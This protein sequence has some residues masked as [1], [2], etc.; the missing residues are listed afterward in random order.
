MSYASYIVPISILFLL[1]QFN[2]VQKKDIRPTSY[3]QLLFGLIAGIVLQKHFNF[4]PTGSLLLPLAIVTTIIAITTIVRN[5]KMFFLSFVLLGALALSIQQTTFET[6]QLSAQ[7]TE[8]SGIVLDKKEL[9]HAERNRYSY[10]EAITIGGKEK[11]IAY[12]RKRT[13]LTPGDKIN[14]RVQAPAKTGP[15]GP[16]RDYMMKEGVARTIFINGQRPA[17]KLNYEIINTKS[18]S[19][20][21]KIARTRYF[22][23]ERL[24]RKIPAKTFAY[25]SSIFMGN[26]SFVPPKEPFY[27]WGTAHHLARSGLHIALFILIWAYLL[28]LA[29]LP[30]AMKQM[31]L[32]A[33]CI[34]YTLLSWSSVS[35]MRA[36]SIFFVFQAGK[37]FKQPTNFLYILQL[38]AFFVLA[39]NPIQLFFLDFQL[40]FGLT[41]ALALAHNAKSNEA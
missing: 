30:F 27:Y 21:Q 10:K 18:E 37:I 32:A 9:T 4:I 40:S 17:S 11:I 38:I 2:V 13:N 22:L 36:I 26:R 6:A 29:P 34:T 25:F 33:I 19:L 23:F 14:I 7:K 5:A 12:T 15:N 20:I 16:F 1:A 39:T 31:A 8:F 41:L 35:F 3:L 28:S 24:K